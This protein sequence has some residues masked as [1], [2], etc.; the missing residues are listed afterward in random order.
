M[1]G[2]MLQEAID[3]QLRS[4]YRERIV[5]PRRRR[6]RH[7]L[8]RAVE[9]GLARADA[10]IEYAVAACTGTLYSL[11]LAGRPAGRDWPERT[12]ALIWR[13]IGGTAVADTSTSRRP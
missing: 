12:A 4:L 7:I 2:S 8:S 9:L 13:S 11:H 1:V 5:D 3:E 6:L 10:D